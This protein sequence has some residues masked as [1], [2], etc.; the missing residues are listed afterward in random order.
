M[1]KQ[2]KSGNLHVLIGSSG[3]VAAIKLP[4]IVKELSQYERLEVQVVTTTSALHFFQPSQLLDAEGEPVKVWTDDEEWK[5]WSKISDPIVHIELRR[6]ADVILVCPCS[7]NT[8]AKI[9]NGLCDNLLTSLIRATDPKDTPVIIFP[10]MN[11]LMY[12]HPLTRKQLKTVVEEIGMEVEGPISKTLA[13]GDIGLGAMTE[14]KDIVD[15][16]V[17]RFLTNP[18]KKPTAH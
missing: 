8:L 5:S 7:A 17:T 2:S 18:S 15:L 11:T 6:W 9:S 10:S 1:E 14:W 13:C 16:I 3:S 4:L 12:D